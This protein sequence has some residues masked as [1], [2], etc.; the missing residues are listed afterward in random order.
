MVQATL[1]VYVSLACALYLVIRTRFA[2]TGAIVLPTSKMTGREWLLASI[3]FFGLFTYAILSVA[4]RSQPYTRP[5]GFFVAIGVLAALLAVEIIRLPARQG[6]EYAVLFKIVLIGVLLRW[7]PQLMFPGHVALDPWGH[8]Y[9]VREILSTFHIP[10]LGPLTYSKVPVMHLHLAST[11]L[12]TGLDF[13][14]S[15]M[16]LM[17]SL[18]VIV[19]ATFTYLLAVRFITGKR[20]AL[21]AALLVTVADIVVFNGFLAYP[22]TLAVMLLSAILYVVLRARQASSMRWT[23]LGLVLMATLILTHTLVSLAMAM[24]LLCFW[25]GFEVYKRL[26]RSRAGI[27]L[28][29]LSLVA[30]FSIAMLSW[31]IYAS[32][33][34]LFLAQVIRWALRA[35]YFLAP[36]PEAARAYAAS[37]PVSEILL[38]IAGFSVFYTF[39]AIGC[40]YLASIKSPGGARGF[41]LA[42]VGI[43]FAAFAFLGPVLNLFVLPDRWYLM[44]QVA[45]AI[46]TALGMIMVA[47]LGRGRQDVLLGI[48]V[49]LVTFSMVAD[50]AANFDTPVFSSARNI[51]R[52]FTEG[53]L[54]SMETIADLWDGVV[55]SDR[56]ATAYLTYG[57]GVATYAINDALDE[58]DFTLLAGTAILIR[59]YITNSPF[60]AEGPWKLGYDPRDLLE[61]QGFGRLYDS[62]SASLFYKEMQDK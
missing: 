14:I 43:L 27:P 10:Q 16:L 1:V 20:I 28:V 3:A 9:I 22:T 23:A 41:A 13:E 19:Q 54:R 44:S 40:L 11:M 45:L 31:W 25:A 39:A 52:A 48:L 33:H 4:L 42:L 46:P 30:L 50:A 15:F 6:Y 32:G 8:E 18:Q 7:A 56:H 62:G 5:L 55:G 35:E 51:R 53:E 26:H 47:G 57:G 2:G 21:L 36:V 60:Y 37:I 17:S 29:A 12:M 61:R 49:G 58:K 38:D 59:D 24:L 34:I